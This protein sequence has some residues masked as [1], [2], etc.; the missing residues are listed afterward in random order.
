MKHKHSRRF[1]TQKMEKY[2]YIGDF[3]KIISLKSTIQNCCSSFVKSQWCELLVTY[4]KIN[5]QWRFFDSK[6]PTVTHA[7]WINQHFIE[8]DILQGKIW[9]Q[10]LKLTSTKTSRKNIVWHEIQWFSA[11][12]LSWRQDSFLAKKTLRLLQY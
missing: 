2:V 6:L 5:H 1:V 12:W 4:K 10:I 9:I 7:V 8:A 11:V 3:R